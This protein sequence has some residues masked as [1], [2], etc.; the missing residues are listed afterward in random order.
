MDNV[1]SDKTLEDDSRISKL[2]ARL[3]AIDEKTLNALGSNSVIEAVVKRAGDNLL[4]SPL[5]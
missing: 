4:D 2:E 1:K 3:N 5:F